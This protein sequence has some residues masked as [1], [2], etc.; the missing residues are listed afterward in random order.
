[1]TLVQLPAKLTEEEQALQRKYQKLKRKVRSVV[2][3][4]QAKIFKNV[5]RKNYCNN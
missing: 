3:Q 5:F 2:C 1:M 4:T